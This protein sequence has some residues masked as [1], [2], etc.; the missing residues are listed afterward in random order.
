MPAI[1]CRAAAVTCFPIACKLGQEVH[2]GGT[3]FCTRPGDVFPA[4]LDGI[5]KSGPDGRNRS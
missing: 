1:A 4:T 5:R 3:E 2:R